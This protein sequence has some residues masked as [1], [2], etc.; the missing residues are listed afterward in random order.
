MSEVIKNENVFDVNKRFIDFAGLDYF[1]GQAKAYVDAQ[2]AALGAR[3]DKVAGDLSDLS[4][5][6]GELTGDAGAG[7]SIAD[8]INAAIEALKLDETYEKVGVAETKANAAK[9][10]AIA[11]ANLY[12]DGLAKNYDA[13]GSAAQALVDAK[14]YADGLASNYDAAGSAAAVLGTDAD[15]ADK[16]TVYGVRAYVDSKD[17]TMDGRVAKLEKIDHDKLAADAS[18]AAVAT[19]LDG[20]PEKFDTLKEVAQWIADSE[21]AADAADLVT[22]VGALETNK[23]DITYVDGLDTAIKARVKDLEDHKDDYVT[24]DN[25][26]ATT[27][28]GEIATAKSGAE[29]TAASYTDGKVAEVSGTVATLSQTVADNLEAA[30]SHADGVAATA[31]TEAIADTVEKLKSYTNT[32]DMAALIAAAKAEAIADAKG[33]IDTLTETVN[34][35]ADKTYVD[36]QDANVLASAKGYA[37]AYTDQLFASVKFASETEIKGIFE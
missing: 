3:I 30:K 36:T 25:T 34:L 22:R 7:A 13:S 5:I 21:S 18:A 37:A 23:A 16:A 20:A 9:D 33:K 19:I 12:A 26:L 35:K 24:A 6:V 29:T 27:L 31:K 11:A 32:T 8:R 1:W 4:S 15:T 2:D 28:R 10:A 17:S 14:A